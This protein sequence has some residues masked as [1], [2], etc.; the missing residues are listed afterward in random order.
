M[1]A[2]AVITADGVA[3]RAL[4]G[5]VARFAAGRT[6]I[7]GAPLHRGLRG[8]GLR[9]A[10][11]SIT[12]RR[13]LFV[14]FDDAIGI[15]RDNLEGEAASGCRCLVGIGVSTGAGRRSSNIQ[16]DCRPR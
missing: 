9:Y 13:K 8:V 14:R 2:V 12:I 7:A 10:S 5:G 4:D 3:L 15:R 6:G 11:L 1:L 16:R